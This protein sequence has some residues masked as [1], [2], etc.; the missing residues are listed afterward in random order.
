[1]V[2]GTL[3]VIIPVFNG[4]RFLPE[5]VASVRRAGLPIEIVIVDDGSTDETEAVANNLGDDV[6]YVR[7]ENQG[8]AAARNRGLELARGKFVAFLDAD[9][10]WAGDHPKTALNYIE[11]AEVDLVLGRTQCLVA[12]G[13][14]FAPSGKEFH[15]YQLGAAICRRALLERIGPFDPN[16][17]YGEDV[18]WFLRVRESGAAIAT[19]PELTLYYRLHSGNQ[20]GVYQNSRAG[21]LNAFHQSLQRRRA[22]AESP[23]GRPLVS[24]VIP[25]RNGVQFIAAAIESVLAQDYRPLELIVV[26]DDSS[27]GTREVVKKF[28]QVSLQIQSHRGA[29]A[30]RNAGVRAAKGELIAFLDADDLWTREK[31]SKQVAAFEHDAGLEAVFGHVAEFEDANSAANGREIPGPIPGTMLIKR[32]AFARI[33]WFDASADSLEGADWYLRALEKS[34]RARMLPEVVYRR[35]IHGNNRSIVQRD[36]HG[37]VRAIKA[38]LDRRRAGEKSP[39]LRAAGFVARSGGTRRYSPRSPA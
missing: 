36:L 10:L 13:V 3:S 26:D 4:E 2:S 24:V 35:R 12:S 6:A 8:P 5:A 31:L 9:D 18:D 25:V 15:S 16:M 1:M 37:Y 33:G 20:P 19:L 38:S 30:A 14:D 39:D 29:G 7:Q 21:L 23:T 34:L 17:R 11:R 32:A 28:A 22:G 27:D